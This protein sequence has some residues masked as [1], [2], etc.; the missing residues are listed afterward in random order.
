MSDEGALSKDGSACSIRT[1]AD[2][3]VP[4]RAPL[5]RLCRFRGKLQ[6]RDLALA[7]DGREGHGALVSVGPSKRP[8]DPGNEP[9]DIYSTV[10]E[11][12]QRIDQVDVVFTLALQLA[13][14]HSP[15]LI[16][17]NHFPVEIEKVRR[18]LGVRGGIGSH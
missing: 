13:L 18:R 5:V 1:Y 2:A 14:R 4:I 11:A 6:Q 17:P 9:V 7:I 15:I 12:S 16:E 10:V 3:L 8:D